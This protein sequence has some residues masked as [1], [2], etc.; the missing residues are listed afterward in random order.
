MC[1]D[2]AGEYHDPAD[3]RFHAQPVCCPA[4]G[5]RLRLLDA[6]GDDLPGEPL[7]AA[8]ALLAGGA[9][10][11]SRGSVA[12]TSRG[13][14]RDEAAVAALRARKHREDKPFA[15]DGRRPGGRAR[16]VRDRRGGGGAADGRAAAGGAA[17]A[18]PGRA[19]RAGRRAGQPQLGVML[20]YTPLHHLLLARSAARSC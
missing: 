14:G 13:R 3:R 15:R 6:N 17:A 10:S 5:P 2:C 18:P 8:A 16:A 11:R 19:A 7:A 1:A 20:P 9:C 12:T 4:C